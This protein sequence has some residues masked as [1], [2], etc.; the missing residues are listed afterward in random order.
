LPDYEPV[1]AITSILKISPN[2]DRM[3]QLVES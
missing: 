3:E 1:T 2:I